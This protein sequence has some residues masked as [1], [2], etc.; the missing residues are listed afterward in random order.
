MT[1]IISFY[2]K[3]ILE[4]WTTNYLFQPMARKM[5]PKKRINREID[6]TVNQS[7]FISKID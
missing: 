2:G 4:S 7:Y 3:I 1:K 6:E 5:K